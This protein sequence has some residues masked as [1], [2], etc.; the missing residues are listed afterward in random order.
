MC[1]DCGYHQRQRAAGNRD[2]KDKLGQQVA[3]AA[4]R[5]D[6]SHERLQRALVEGGQYIGKPRVQIR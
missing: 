2:G 3:D 5:E 1:L 4:K 6:G